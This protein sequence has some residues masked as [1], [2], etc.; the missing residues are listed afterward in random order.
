MQRLSI[1]LRIGACLALVGVLG[2]CATMN[3]EDCQ[4]ADWQ[5]LGYNDASSGSG[6]A[7]GRRRAEA[8]QELGFGADMGAYGRG[9]QDGLRVFCTPGGAENFARRGGRYE[10]GYCPP[11]LEPQFLYYYRPAFERF[12]YQRRMRELQNDIDRQYR[13]IDRLRE[14]QRKGE[15]VGD[16]L[17]RAEREL[18]RLR[19]RMNTESMLRY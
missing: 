7:T 1:A 16:R 4:K 13:E 15:N 9:W 6:S 3:A 12:E 19:D 10:T 11:E 17:H 14:R 2:G 5:S 8:C 18:R